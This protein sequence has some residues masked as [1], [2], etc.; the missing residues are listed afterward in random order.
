M[1]KVSIK[2]LSAIG[3]RY[4]PGHYGIEDRTGV[5]MTE[6]IDFHLVQIAAWP[7]TL[8]EVAGRAAQLIG[9]ELAPGPGQ[10]AATEK[11]VLLRVEPL[12]LWLLA[13]SEERIALL[14]IEPQAG[15]TLD[16][17]HSRTWLRIRGEAA[18]TLLNH[19]LPIDFRQSKFSPGTVISTAFH[20]IGISLYYQNGVFNLF[21]PRS[22]ALSLWELLYQSSLQYGLEITPEERVN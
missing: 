2:P 14:N 8:A 21:L 7:E 17:S 11:G 22:F 10:C 3:K 6:V 4:V 5:I 16:L 9:S 12:K 18:T 15:S 20:H 19:F 13:S 1:D